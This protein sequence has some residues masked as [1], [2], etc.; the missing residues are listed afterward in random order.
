MELILT[1]P[2]LYSSDQ[3]DYIRGIKPLE[4]DDL[5]ESSITASC[6]D[7]IG[8]LLTPN[9]IYRPTAEAAISHSWFAQVALWLD[10]DD[11]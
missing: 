5:S 10:Q 4:F 1:H 9:P 2:F 8:S 6:Q 7:F 3:E 11:S